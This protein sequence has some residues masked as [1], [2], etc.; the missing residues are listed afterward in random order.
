MHAATGAHNGVKSVTE[1]VQCI[2]RAMCV[3]TAMP[4]AV[5]SELEPQLWLGFVRGLADQ[6]SLAIGV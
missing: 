6:T 3:T 4:V 2:C 5:G 1:I